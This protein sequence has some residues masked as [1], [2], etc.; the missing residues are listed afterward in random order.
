[1]ERDQSKIR[2]SKMS[3]RLELVRQERE[4]KTRDQSEQDQSELGFRLLL[5]A[6]A[7]PWQQALTKPKSAYSATKAARAS[8][9]AILDWAQVQRR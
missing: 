6:R 4:T 1:M 8:P 3:A 5:S 9:R 7:L 2:A